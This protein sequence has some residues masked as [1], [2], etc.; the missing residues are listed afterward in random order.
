MADIKRVN[1]LMQEQDL[2][3]LK[4]IKIPIQKHSFL[5]ETYTDI[6]DPQEEMPHSS[7]TL[8]P[9]DRARAHPH[10]QEVTDFLMEVD[11]DIEKLIQTTNDQDED[12]LENSEQQQKFGVRG[13]RPSSH[14]SDWGIQWWNALVAMLLIGIILPLFYVIYFKIKDNGLSTVS[15]GAT[16]SPITSPNASGTDLH[17]RG[18]EDFQEPG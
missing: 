10:L 14:G 3:A 4:S 5:T 1:N 12:F 16:Q 2:F 13:E 9:R 17:V 18:V 6:S 11:Q 15:S 8:K 7:A